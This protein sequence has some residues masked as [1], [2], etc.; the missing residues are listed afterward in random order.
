MRVAVSQGPVLLLQS[1][2]VFK[3]HSVQEITTTIFKKEEPRH[4]AG[5]TPPAY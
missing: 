1:T 3:K 4:G 2:T 5:G